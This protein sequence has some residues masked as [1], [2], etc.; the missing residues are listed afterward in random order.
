MNALGAAAAALAIGLPPAAVATG[1]ESL[2]AVPGRLEPVS[3][4]QDF[5]VLVDYAHTPDA[6]DKVLD[7]LRPLTRGRLRVV[8]GCGGDRDRTKRPLMGRAVAAR[9]DALYLTSDNPRSEDPESILDEVF[10]GIPADMHAATLRE[11]D[12]R[13]AIRRACHDAAP[14]DV[15]LIA[16]KGH[17]TT[18]TIGSRVLPFDDRAVAREVLWSL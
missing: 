5:R 7:L 11:V 8:F 10:A 13:E 9:A 2:P 17:E 3:C 16:G 14:G 12:R 18:Q 1:L 4:G 15:L 6:L